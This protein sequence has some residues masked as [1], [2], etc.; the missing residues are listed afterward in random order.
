MYWALEPGT[1]I[2]L[3]RD[4][5]RLQALNRESRLLLRPS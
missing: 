1:G 3:E 5:L 2:R 4:G